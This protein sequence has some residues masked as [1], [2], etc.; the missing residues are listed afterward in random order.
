MKKVYAIILAGGQSTRFN[1]ELPKQ[2]QKLSGKVIIEHTID[3][4]ER[5]PLIDEIIVVVNPM[6]RYFVEEMVV[7]KKYGKVRK[8]LNGGKTRQDSSKIGV[9]SIEEE[10]AY[11]LIHDAV[12]P[13]IS[14]NIITKSIQALD[15]YDAVDVA[16]DSPDTI[17][18]HD[19]SRTIVEEIPD[20]NRLMLGQTPQGFRLSIIRKAY[21]MYEKEPVAV[22]DDCGLIVKYKLGRVGI[23]LGERF[24][25][26]ITYAEDMYLA[27]K[28]FQVRTQQIPAFN[29][30]VLKELSGK[31]IVV[32][33][34]TKGIGKSVVEHA[35]EYGAYAYG[36]SRATGTNVS[37]PASVREALKYVYNMHGKIDYVINTAAIMNMGPIE[38]REYD[39][40][41]NEISTNYFGSIVVA[42]ESHRFL[43]ETKGMLVLFTS[44]SYTRG[45]E[46]YSVYSSSKAA[47]VN[48]AQALCNEWTTDGCRVNVINPE[49]TNTELRRRNFGYE[50]SSTLLSPD[51]VAEQTLRVL[52][53]NCSG[54]VFD[55]RKL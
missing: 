16:V 18:V 54:Q 38:T 46:L 42:K 14:D 36:F 49:R 29:I 44:S 32:F 21:E 1:S 41:Q 2:F 45:R 47:I 4:F 35:V 13:F 48:F 31:V 19:E 28:I 34:G 6:F 51:Y 53:L 37:N 9:F 5:H 10:D 26:K 39:S 17:I 7:S 40:I 55:I 27:D 11:V 50:D 25:I 15:E 52:L 30:N 23:V 33:G 12:R 24:N 22:T 8:I 43:K 3:V 20:R